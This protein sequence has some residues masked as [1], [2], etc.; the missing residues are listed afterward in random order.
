MQSCNRSSLIAFIVFFIFYWILCT[1]LWIFIKYQHND[2]IPLWLSL[3]LGFWGVALTLF[4]VLSLLFFFV[5][6]RPDSEE[7]NTTS[8]ESETQTGNLRSLEC[9]RQGERLDELESVNLNRPSSLD[10][11]FVGQAPPRYVNIN[12]I[13]IN[14]RRNDTMTQEKLDLKEPPPM[15]INLQNYKAPSIEC[16]TVMTE[17]SGVTCIPIPTIHRDCSLKKTEVFL[18]IN[19]DR[20]WVEQRILSIMLANKCVY[21]KFC[22]LMLTQ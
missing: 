14:E 4:G 8:K 20:R 6:C 10:L 9:E 16:E 11:S 7:Y 1:A 17:N 13:M 12:D 22:F 21:L 5:R 3:P 2:N 18:F 15:K 19:D